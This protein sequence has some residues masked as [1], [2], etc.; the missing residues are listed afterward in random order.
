VKKR[1]PKRR[2]SILR[3]VIFG[4]G[5]VVVGGMGYTCGWL[6]TDSVKG[7]LCVLAFVEAL[8][9]AYIVECVRTADDE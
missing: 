3:T 5:V 4:T 6:Y 7:G 2:R 1:I 8:M 9:F